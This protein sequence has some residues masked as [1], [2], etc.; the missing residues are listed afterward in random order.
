VDR[1]QRQDEEL[2]RQ[3][4]EEKKAKKMALAQAQENERL[5]K[6][7]LKSAEDEDMAA[8]MGFS[9]FDSSKSKPKN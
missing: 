8:L 2:K 6:E 9:S 4:K 5:A 1:L 7:S 3:K